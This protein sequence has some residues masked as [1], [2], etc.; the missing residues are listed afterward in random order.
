MPTSPKVVIGAIVTFLG[1]AG[2]VYSLPALS[3]AAASK[4]LVTNEAGVPKL[5]DNMRVFIVFV[6][7]ST[8]VLGLGIALVSWGASETLVP[9]YYAAADR[10]IG[11]KQDKSRDAEAA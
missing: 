2:L 10:K 9:Q 7:G 6:L 3:N 1:V 4:Q 8:A 5:P 11:S